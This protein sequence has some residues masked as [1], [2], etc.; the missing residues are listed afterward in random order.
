LAFNI[1]RFGEDSEQLPTS[2]TCFGK[3]Y[4]PEYKVKEKMKRKLELAIQ[5]AKGFG[6]V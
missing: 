3:L 2:S 5:N 6:V 4:L 1:V